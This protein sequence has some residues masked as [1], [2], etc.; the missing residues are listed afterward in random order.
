MIS[1]TLVKE[2]LTKF[3]RESLYVMY[4]YVR[5]SLL[6]NLENSVQAITVSQKM[7]V[8]GTIYNVMKEYVIYVIIIKLGASFTTC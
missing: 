5:N 1:T 4:M 8:T 2:S 7:L 3:L 6:H